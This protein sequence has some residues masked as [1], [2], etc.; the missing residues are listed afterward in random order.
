VQ[1]IRDALAK[2]DNHDAVALLVKRNQGSVFVAM[3]N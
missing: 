2:A 3:A 1:E